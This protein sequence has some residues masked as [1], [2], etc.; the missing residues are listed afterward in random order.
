MTEDKMVGCH[1]Q[2]NR[3]EFEQTLEDGDMEAWCATAHGVAK[4][5]TWLSE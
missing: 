1:H 3:H 5:Q 2:V 4:S